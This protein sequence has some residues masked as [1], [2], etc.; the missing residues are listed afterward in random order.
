M[1]SVYLRFIPPDRDD[2]VKLHI[3]EAPDLTSALQ[4][5]EIVEN[6]GVYPDYIN[7][8]TTTNAV[9]TTDYFAI[10]WE[11]D[12]GAFTDMSSRIQGGTSTLI[13]I[14]TERVMLRDP[15][16]DENIVLQETEAVVS[17]ILRVSDPYSVDPTTLSSL[18]INSLAD[19][20]LIATLYLTATQTTARGQDY[21]AGMISE[22]TTA[23]SNALNNLER[24]EKR[25]MRR[26]G[27][28]GS[29]IAAICDD[30]YVTYVTGVKTAFDSSRILET[31]GVLT[32]RIVERDLDSGLLISDNDRLIDTTNIET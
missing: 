15:D 2:L 24:L 13:G 29:I 20:A 9:N 16:L 3:F 1:A 28:G 14:L 11:D 7:E 12:K 31:R 27:I 32:D 21:T 17:Y 6:I 4:E 30:F 10:Q 23:D 8:Y 25:I 26:L 5:I 18:W 19:L 22:R